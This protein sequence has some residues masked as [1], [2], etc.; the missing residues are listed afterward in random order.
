MEPFEEIP[1]KYKEICDTLKNTTIKEKYFDA[2]SEY[3]NNTIKKDGKIL[4]IGSGRMESICEIASLFFSAKDLRNIYCSSDSSYPKKIKEKDTV[5]AV[6]GSGSTDRTINKLYPAIDAEANI[7]GITANKNSELSELVSEKD[8]L[9]ILLDGKHKEYDDTYYERQI[10][11]KHNP[12]NLE[13]TEIELNTLLFFT[14]YF[15]SEETGRTPTEFHKSFCETLCS[16]TP[17]PTEFIKAYELLPEVTDFEKQIY[18]LNKTITVGEGLSGKM[19]DLFRI[20]LGHCAKKNQERR[21]ESYK[22][23]NSIKEG[24]TV[25]IFSV[26]GEGLPYKY[27]KKSK[28]K[29]ANIISITSENSPLDKISD[30]V[31]HIPNREEKKGKGE[32][33]HIQPNPEKCLPEYIALLNS[34]CFVYST[35]NYEN[36]EESDLK[37]HH[38]D[39]T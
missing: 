25:F 18:S 20:R 23:A 29:D 13:G 32:V 37:Y 30:S 28:T 12:L 14:N 27:A 19:S 1:Q 5:I 11:G 10:N 36:L 34:E 26:S 2:F 17:D 15:G 24:D 31:I 16:Y 33:Y 21:V 39:F 22:T 6:S 38:S 35:V 3:I 9:L 7:I 8:N 4:L